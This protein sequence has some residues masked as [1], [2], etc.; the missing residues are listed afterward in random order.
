MGPRT[1]SCHV[2]RPKEGSWAGS[3]RR[4]QPCALDQTEKPTL[5]QDVERAC[6][7]FGGDRSPSPR[8]VRRVW[9]A[10]HSVRG[11][12][13]NGTG[14]AG[15]GSAPSYP[16]RV[17]LQDRTK[18][19]RKPRGKSRVSIW[20]LRERNRGTGEEYKSIPVMVKPPR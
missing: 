3:C 1:F 18:A 2:V 7:G 9:Q 14:R 12:G 16:S 10:E 5:L 8:R 20:P 15:R 4:S 11:H 6:G 13:V 19:K 17:S